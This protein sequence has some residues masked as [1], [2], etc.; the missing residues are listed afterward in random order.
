VDPK[1]HVLD[2][3]RDPDF[4]RE[5]HLGDATLCQ[6]TVDTSFNLLLGPLVEDLYV[7]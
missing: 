4:P 1:N 5:G 2:G 6:I 3:D 7:A